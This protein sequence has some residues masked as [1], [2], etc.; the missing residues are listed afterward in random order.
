MSF[1]KVI[2]R[3]EE[4][5]HIDQVGLPKPLA[6][7]LNQTG[8]LFQFIQKLYGFVLSAVHFLHDLCDRIDDIN[9]ILLVPP[10]VFMR[11]PYPVQKKT[12][13]QLRF[14]RDP[15]IGFVLQKQLWDSDKRVL[16]L[17]HVIEIVIHSY[18]HLLNGK[19]VFGKGLAPEDVLI[20]LAIGAG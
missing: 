4:A 2:H 12:V 20:L 15:L 16:R 1:P 11:K 7:P 14:R 18:H 19:P 10:A 13:Q 9:A 6:L 3:P 8:F 5:F 17:I